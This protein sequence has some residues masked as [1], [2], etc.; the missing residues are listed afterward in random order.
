MVLQPSDGDLMVG[1]PQGRAPASVPTAHLSA[2]HQRLHR[3]PPAHTWPP[4]RA[5]SRGCSKRVSTE[6]QGSSGLIPGAGP[7]Q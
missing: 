6:R 2:G 5:L 7:N 1:I 4:G 3:K